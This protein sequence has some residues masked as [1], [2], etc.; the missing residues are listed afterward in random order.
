MEMIIFHCT[1]AKI[2]PAGLSTMATGVAATSTASKPSATVEPDTLDKAS[3][4]TPVGEDAVTGA[5]TETAGKAT[6]KSRS[7]S[8]KRQSIF[9]KVLGKKE[10]HDEKKEMKKEEKSE[11]KAEKKEEKVDQK[12]MKKEEKAEQKELKREEKAEKKEEKAEDKLEKKEEKAELNA[13]K[14]EAKHVDKPA[15]VEPAPLDAA[16]VG[17]WCQLSRNVFGI[18]L[19]S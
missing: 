6:T 2:C 15:A 18:I 19:M 17:E 3:E 13:E 14:K 10:E 9:G 1:K 8:R 4:T 11:E 16:A 12:E 5:S 7:Q